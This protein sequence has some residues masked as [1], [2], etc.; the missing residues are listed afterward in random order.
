[1]MGNLDYYKCFT[2]HCGWQFLFSK[3]NWLE[4]VKYIFEKYFEPEN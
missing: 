4:Y 1:M 2:S 3:K